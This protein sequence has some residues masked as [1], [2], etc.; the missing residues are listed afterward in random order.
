MDV[1]WL[2]STIHNTFDA[3][4]DHYDMI[5]C[6]VQLTTSSLCGFDSFL[7]LIFGISK[8]DA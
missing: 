8:S 2:I 7:F 1:G 4:A 3:S 6:R 5:I